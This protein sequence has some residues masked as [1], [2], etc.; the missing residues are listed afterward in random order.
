MNK[1]LFALLLIPLISFS[2]VE[3]NKISQYL[4]DA[5]ID[6]E[7]PG[8]SVAIVKD[9]EI[10][11]CKGFGIK[12]AGKVEKVDGKTLFAIASNTKAFVSSALSILVSKDKIS[13][14][15]KVKKY[16]PEFELYDHYVSQETTIR[17]LLCHRGGLGTFSGDYMWYKSGLTV[18]QLIANLKYVPKAYSFRSG[19]GYSNLMFITAGEVIKRVSGVEWNEFVT[20]ELL[21]PLEMS[22]T[23]TSTDKINK[24]N[25]Y[26]TPHKPFEAG[27]EP[28]PWVNW[29]NM[30]A[31][32]GI[33][34]S[35]EDMSKWLIMQLND[36]IWKDDTLITRKEQVNMWTPHNNFTVSDRSVER[37]PGR[38]F[39][40]YGLGWSLGDYYGNMIVSHGGGYDG[41]YSKVFMVPDHN[42]GIVV[43]TNSM[44][45][46]TTP[47]CYY[48]VNQYIKKDMRD[49]SIEA[50][51]RSQ[52]SNSEPSKIEKIKSAKVKRTNPSITLDKYEGT[53]WSGLHG[54]VSITK[55]EDNFRMLFANSHALSASLKHWHYD[56]WEIIW[57]E[58]HAWFDFGIVQFKIDSKLEVEGLR[59]DVPNYDIFFD[60]IDLIKIKLTTSFY[61]L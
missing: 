22:R 34:S 43:L 36:G 12:E 14:D 31:A 45:G 18:D 60:E 38:H 61:C 33:I 44:K 26:A 52:L 28:I 3:T 1:L 29:D 25:N 10:V 6:W 16:I 48:I 54:E 35:A 19:Y 24:S 40:G 23:I 17:D 20:N 42:L 39:S 53:Y 57:D 13:W 51:K 4:S 15:D 46:I 2:Q 11:F 9:G 21:N 58:K 8:M 30:G 27:N 7:I 47:L 49:W 50:L 32:G 41:M 55:N 56:T 59:I 37:I 5:R